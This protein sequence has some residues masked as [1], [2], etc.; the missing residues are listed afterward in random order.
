MKKILVGLLCMT[1]IIFNVFSQENELKMINVAIQTKDSIYQIEILEHEVPVSLYIKYMGE[2]PEKKVEENLTSVSNLLKSFSFGSAKKQETEEQKKSYYQEIGIHDNHPV[3]AISFFDAIYFCNILSAR[4]NLT[5]VY[6][7]DGN[8]NVNF[9]NYTPHKG[10]HISGKV[11][12]DEEANG[13]RLPTL[14]EWLWVFKY[15]EKNFDY[16]GSD[17]IDEVAWYKKNSDG[18][19][20]EVAQK[21]PNSIGLYDLAGNVKEWIYEPFEQEPGEYGFSDPDHKFTT[22]V[23]GGGF[24]QS[25]FSCR[26][27]TNFRTTPGL[28]QS[29]EDTGFRIVRTIK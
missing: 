28:K 3:V 19:T 18:T 5:P 8:T 26:P 12:Q 29:T 23:V 11:T 21:K 14:Y 1:I 22:P 4:N 20:H 10:N 27:D 6:S 25:A 9:W 17:N 24:N 15:D 13:Y 7:V 16:P 2:L